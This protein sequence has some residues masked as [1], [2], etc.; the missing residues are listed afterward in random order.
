MLRPRIVSILRSPLSG[1]F[2]FLSALA[3]F[4]TWPQGL[5]LGTYSREVHTAL[6]LRIL[7]RPEL[8]SQ[9]K[10]RDRLG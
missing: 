6:M 10:Y 9:G 2:V 3:L 7:R 1:A 8:V 4:L 5:H